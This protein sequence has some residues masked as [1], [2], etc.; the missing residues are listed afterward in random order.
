MIKLT[1]QTFLGLWLDKLPVDFCQRLDETFTRWFDVS[2]Y[3]PLVVREFVDTTSASQLRYLP[4]GNTSP[5]KD[6]QYTKTDVTANTV[7]IYPYGTQT[8]NAGATYVLAAQGDTVWLMFDKASQSW[9]S[10]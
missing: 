9:W 3:I 5:D 4:N 2:P 1:R 6:Y 7:T 10:A 8:I